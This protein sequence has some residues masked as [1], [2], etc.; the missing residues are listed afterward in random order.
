MN[1]V[2]PGDE[3]VPLPTLPKLPTNLNE[4]FEFAGNLVI[5]VKEALLPDSKEETAAKEEK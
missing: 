2:K 5:K 4:T 3:P 1:A